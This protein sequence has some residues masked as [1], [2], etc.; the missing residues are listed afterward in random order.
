MVADRILFPAVP[1]R[2]RQNAQ[3]SDT[4]AKPNFVIGVRDGLQNGVGFGQFRKAF[5]E[6]EQNRGRSF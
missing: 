4:L 6:A 1:S 3:K 2:V 5:T